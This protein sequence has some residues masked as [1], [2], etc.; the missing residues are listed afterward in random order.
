VTAEG[1]GCSEND[2][3]YGGMGV[4]RNSWPIWRDK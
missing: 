3:K 2:N 1:E 4:E